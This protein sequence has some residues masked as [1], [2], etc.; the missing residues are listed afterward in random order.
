MKGGAWLIK[1]VENDINPKLLKR[2][3]QQRGFNMR[4]LDVTVA[5]DLYDNTNLDKNVYGLNP[6]WE[7]FKSKN[8]EL[9]EK[10]YND[11]IDENVFDDV[12]DLLEDVES[13]RDAYETARKN[14]EQWYPIGNLKD[15]IKVFKSPAAQR[16]FVNESIFHRYYGEGT[17]LHYDNRPFGYGWMVEFENFPGKLFTFFSTN[18]RWLGSEGESGDKGG[19]GNILIK[20][21]PEYL[22]CQLYTLYKKY[23]KSKT[24]QNSL[25]EGMVRYPFTYK[26]LSEK[27]FKDED[28]P[29]LSEETSES[30]FE[31]KLNDVGRNYLKKGKNPVIKNLNFPNVTK[32]DLSNL[33]KYCLFLKFL[34]SIRDNKGRFIRKWWQFYAGNKIDKKLIKD[35][36]M[37][38]KVGGGKR[39]SLLD[40]LFGCVFCAGTKGIG[41]II[42]F[43]MAIKKIK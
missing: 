18:S 40:V 6:S 33:H 12:E 38:H 8:K 9:Y 16:N 4:K 39:L 3:P 24:I 36:N 17:I 15:T 11:K 32:N 42:I 10:K 20:Q 14:I 43:L 1:D 5:E 28:F 25:F 29:D 35:E 34:N 41:C 2:V 30:E 37:S 22:I 27:I 21:P 13:S 31:N 19:K 26:E 7:D 23:P